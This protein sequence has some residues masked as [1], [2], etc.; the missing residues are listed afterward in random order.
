MAALGFVLVALLPVVGTGA[1][2]MPDEGAAILQ[3]QSLSEGGGWIVEHPVP[4]VDE[5]GR[6]YPLELAAEGSKG[7]APFA[8]HPLYAVMLAGAHRVGGTAAMVGLSVVGTVLAAGLAALLAGRLSPG[9]A[10]PAVWATG[11]GSPL[12]F[13]GYLVMAHTLGAAAAA[14]A[15]LAAVV[16]GDRG[17]WRLALLVGPLVALTVLLRNEGL[18]LAL[19]LAVAGTVVAVRRP[20]AR[21]AGLVTA[22][23]AGAAA[24]LAH[25]GERMWVGAVV[26]GNLERVAVPFTGGSEGLLEGRLQAFLLTWLTPAYDP[27]PAVVVPLVLMVL[28]LAVGAFLAGRS[29]PAAAL[30]AAGAVASVAALTAMVANRSTIVPGLLVT[31]PLAVVGLVALRRGLLARPDV[32]ISGVVTV[33]FCLGVLAT[34]YST[35]GTGEW[36][37]RYF[38][39]IVPVAVPVLLLA[40]TSRV[41]ALA[42]PA[43]V[44][45]LGAVVACS[46]ALAGMAVKSLR[47]NHQAKLQVIAAIERAG[48]EA[49]PGDGA[50]PVVVGT[51]VG[52]ARQA[53]PIF[54]EHRWLLVSSSELRGLVTDLVSSRVDRIVLVTSHREWDEPA[55]AGLQ[56]LRGERADSLGVDVLV[57]AGDG[58]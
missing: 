16:A 40:A 1:S 23:S 5:T 50:K 57:V 43:R 14:G 21:A 22:A 19:G 2:F 38:A 58:R 24:L 6:H 32:E 30:G 8:K 33:V 9:L 10:R 52:L 20:T 7:R 39:L 11:I 18:F 46:L 54:D 12:L 28:A 45:A 48:R 41:Q 29:V 47:A 31:F 55:L 25:V 37:G 4:E 3:A 34:Q 13:D 44:V 15:L 36:G 35:G 27:E 56:V 17:R 51:G 53:W 42:P 49:P 26:G